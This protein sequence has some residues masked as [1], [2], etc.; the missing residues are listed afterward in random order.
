M[1]SA[2]TAGVGAAA[3]GA[4]GSA[5]TTGAGWAVGSATTAAGWA[6]G[7]A[8]TGAVG[9]AARDSRDRHKCGP[10]VAAHRRSG[11]D[12][13]IVLTVPEKSATAALLFELGAQ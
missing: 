13:F 9:V 10:V 11:V 1:G 2:T 5:T 6:V 7:S 12:I 3:A 4:M 8:T